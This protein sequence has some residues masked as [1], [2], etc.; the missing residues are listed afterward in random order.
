M[1]DL[2][3]PTKNKWWKSPDV[4]KT[5]ILWIILTIAIGIFG[6]QFHI[7]SMPAPASDVMSGVIGLMS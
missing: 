6:S 7:L 1:T 4:K 3:P 2:L 5:F